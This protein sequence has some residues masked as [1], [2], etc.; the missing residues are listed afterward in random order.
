[1]TQRCNCALRAPTAQRPDELHARHDPPSSPIFASPRFP[2]PTLPRSLPLSLPTLPSLAFRP[3]LLFRLQDLI[4]QPQPG[5]DLEFLGHFHRR[6][7]PQRTAT[8]RQLLGAGRTGLVWAGV[9]AFVC[10]MAE[11]EAFLWNIQ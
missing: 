6:F 9:G 7:V 5:I 1:M 2:L 3:L 4:R 10:V 11:F 8:H